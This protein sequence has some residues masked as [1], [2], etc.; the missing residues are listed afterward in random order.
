MLL[1]ICNLSKQEAEVDK[2]WGEFK[3][4]SKGKKLEELNPCSEDGGK[5][6]P[7]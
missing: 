4:S 2:I 6:A 3:K 1:L 5:P 7:M